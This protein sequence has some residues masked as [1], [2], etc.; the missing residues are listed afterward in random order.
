MTSLSIKDFDAAMTMDA[1]NNGAV[2]KLVKAWEAKNGQSAKRAAGLGLMAVS[3]AACGGSEDEAATVYTVA[4]LKVTEALDAGYE[5]AVVSGNAGEFSVAEL[6]DVRAEIAG[7]ANVAQ[8][9]AAV[10][11]GTITFSVTDTLD[12]VDGVEL[13]GIA[14]LTVNIESE[15][16]GADEYEAEID[17]TGTGTAS[18]NF[19]DTDDVVTLT[20][21]LDGFATLAVLYG[22][23]DL[24]GVALDDSI[25]AITVSSGVILTAAQFLALEDGVTGGSA[26]STVQIVINDADE[27]ADVI[28]AIANL[29]GTLDATNVELVAAEGSDLTANA[30][31]ALNAGLVAQLEQRDASD[32]LPDVLAA[33]MEAYTAAEDHE[34]SLADFLADAVE[35]ETVLAQVDENENGLFDDDEVITTD[36]ITAANDAAAGEFV[37]AGKLID[38]TDLDPE[39]FNSMPVA[40]QDGL[41]NVATTGLETVIEAAEAALEEAEDALEYQVSGMIEAA[42]AALVAKVAADKALSD[43]EEDLPGAEGA[44]EATVQSGLDDSDARFDLVGGKYVVNFVSN[45]YADFDLLVQDEETGVWSIDEGF[46]LDDETGRYTQQSASVRAEEVDAML[47]LLNDINAADL[48]ATAAETAL[49]DAV[50]AAIEAQNPD[51][52]ESTWEYGD[53]SIV[54]GAI[55][56]LDSGIT[57]YVTAVQDLEAAETALSDF[58]AAVE[59]WEATNALVDQYGAWTA[60]GL[61]LQDAYYE[62]AMDLV[63]LGIEPIVIQNA[64]DVL[65]NDAGASPNELFISYADDPD[66]I[67]V[68]GFGADGTDRI[69]F[70]QGDYSF[71]TLDEEIDFADP[72]GSATKLEIFAVENLDDDGEV[73]GVTLLVENVA[74]AGNGT[75]D[76]DFSR[77][78]LNDVSLADISFSSSSNILVSGEYLA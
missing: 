35:N 73:T 47:D 19:A 2:S 76:V 60:T 50:N 58:E 46:E 40:M 28:A 41:I 59:A 10:T 69:Y 11:A 49:E 62:A 9:Q 78:V 33:F 43:L 45:F 20:G 29:G 17:A 7:A 56:W 31:A 1:T 61:E 57:A 15:T 72:L 8:F 14:N 44:V 71:V 3:L 74:S 16:A 34:A 13:A 51:I 4:Q 48:A 32:G 37:G 23:V 42:E 63:D 6:T 66:L 54:D 38:I 24:T 39:D 65:F 26:D 22:T 75:T 55:N 67:N 77:I 18:F 12:N 52:D 5:V 64:N 27:A 25:D 68:E 30:L 53:D 36:D 70:S 21:S